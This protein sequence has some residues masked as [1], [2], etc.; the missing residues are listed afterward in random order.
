MVTICDAIN[1]LIV[2]GLTMF[3]PPNFVTLAELGDEFFSSSYSLLSAQ[4]RQEYCRQ[5]YESPARFGSP[6]DYC[7]DVFISSVERRRIFAA[8]EDGRVQSLVAVME[9]GRSRL[10]SKLSVF[11]S[12]LVAADPIEAG[13]DNFWL[14]KM[15]STFFRPWLE[16]QMT[17]RTLMEAYPVGPAKTVRK[18]REAF[19]TLPNVFERARFTISSQKAP[20][21]IDIIDEHYLPPWTCR[22]LVPPQVLV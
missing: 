2:K 11:E 10:F 13:P 18:D 5:D 9:E 20:W 22:A 15:G 14:T 6:S 21:L 1:C 17:S 12:A 3:C 7:E 8:S 16:R 19:H 4:A